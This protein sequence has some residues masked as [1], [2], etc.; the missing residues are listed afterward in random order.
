LPFHAHAELA[1]EAAQEVFAQKG[2]AAFWAFHDKLFSSDLDDSTRTER[3][4]L[5]RLA[6]EAGLNM[7][8]FEAAL[9][10]GKHRP[11]VDGDA[12]IASR[13]GINGTPAFV[14]NGYY[15]SGAQEEAA[16]K[17]LID[18]ALKGGPPPAT[19]PVATPGT[20]AP[21]AGASPNT[22]E[23][24]HILVAY[25]GALR[26]SSGITRSKAEA[27]KRAEEA[28]AK[29]KNGADFAQIASQ[30]SDDPGTATRG[31][32]LGSFPRASMVKP[33]GDA[34]FALNVNELSGVIETDFGFHLILRT[35]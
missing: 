22:V 12:A 8:A 15:L 27:R 17:K 29:L 6:R 35:K 31:G 9:D 16:F 5:E 7:T 19:A 23:A 13:A 21:T 30:Y 4:N 14:I 18:L 34:A 28:L 33:F 1:A 3:S 20:T 32:A 26:A 25:Q 2:A 24:S 11:K 10:S